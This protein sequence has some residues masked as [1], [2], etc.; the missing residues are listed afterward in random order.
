MKF[1]ENS[2]KNFVKLGKKQCNNH[3]Q[4]P[5]W[6]RQLVTRTQNLT[7][8][9]LLKL[10]NLNLDYSGVQFELLE[11][12][13]CLENHKSD[14]YVFNLVTNACKYI[15]VDRLHEYQSNF[16]SVKPQWNHM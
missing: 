4:C 13:Q 12:A 1:P 10:K 11:S 14:K 9:T 16:S 3:A 7:A 5:A 15:T 2:F 6:L 8:Q